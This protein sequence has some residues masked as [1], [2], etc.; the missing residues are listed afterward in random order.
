MMLIIYW[1]TAAFCL[2]NSL[3]PIPEIFLDFKTVRDKTNFLNKMDKA[4]T[5]IF[6]F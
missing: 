6:F 2:Q 5:I 4:L 1:Y 3:L